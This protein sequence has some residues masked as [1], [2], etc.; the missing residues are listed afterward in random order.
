MACLGSPTTIVTDGEPSKALDRAAHWTGSVSWL[1]SIITTVNWVDRVR[2]RSASCSSSSATRL[3]WSSKV[4]PPVSSSRSSTRSTTRRVSSAT[5]SS[6]G[7]ALLATILMPGL[8]NTMRARAPSRDDD[9]NGIDAPGGSLS[10]SGVGSNAASTSTSATTESTI[11]EGSWTRTAAGSN[12]PVL[13]WAARTWAQKPWMVVMVAVSK[14]TTARSSRRR[15]SAHSSAVPPRRWATRGSGCSDPGARASR[16]R[17]VD[18][19]RV[20]MRSRSSAAAARVKVTTSSSPTGT[21][22]SAT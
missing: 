19:K 11:S 10:G 21:P 1:S 8:D 9:G 3:S 16:S 13:P 22:R 12:G 7:L 2:R 14:S 17:A 15:L 5:S 4:T 6:V 18:A 20:R